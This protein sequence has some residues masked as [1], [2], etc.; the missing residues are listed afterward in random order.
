MEVSG[1]GEGVNE[2]MPRIEVSA[3]EAAREKARLAQRRAP[4]YEVRTVHR[5]SLDCLG[6]DSACMVDPETHHQL[7]KFRQERMT[8]L[9]IQHMK[10]LV[11]SFI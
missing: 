2:R 11:R 6:I 1:L 10:S 8:K 4:Q 7:R 9:A 5:N 3:S